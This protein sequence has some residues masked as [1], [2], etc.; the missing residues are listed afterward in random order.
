MMTS[1]EDLPANVKAI[2]EDCGYTSVKDELTFQL[3]R[4]Y[5]LPAFP[6]VDT[7][8]MLTKIRAGYSFGEASALEQVKK[9]KTPTLFIHGDNDTFVPTEMVHTVYENSPVEKELYIVPNAGHGEAF[10]RDPVK[11]ESV[12][13]EFIGRFVK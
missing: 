6:I 7:T 12:V 2:V 1:G 9:S 4:M 8:S 5:H 10:R 3:K 13:S 11:Y